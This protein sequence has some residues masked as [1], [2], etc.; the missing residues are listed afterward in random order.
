MQSRLRTLMIAVAIAG[1]VMRL[2]VHVR[3]VVRQETD[4]ALAI[5]MLEG[6]LAAG[7]L[8]IGASVGFAVYLVRKDET[9]AAQM[10]RNDVPTQCPWPRAKTHSP[11]QE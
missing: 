4:F 2:V 5:L 1:V 7:L 3:V 6:L 8:T 10:R 11:D 9:Y